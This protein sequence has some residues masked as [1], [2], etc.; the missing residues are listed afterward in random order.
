MGRPVRND[1]PQAGGISGSRIALA[2]AALIAVAAVGVSIARNTSADD[3]APAAASADT[4]APP[5]IAQAITQ[6]EARLKSNPDNVEDWQMLGWSFFETGKFAEA[7]TAY[8]RATR[9]APDSAV[10]WSS[11]G[12]ALVMAGDGSMPKDAEAAFAKAVALDPADPRA[13]YFLSVGK[14]LAGDHKGAIDGWLAL[15][16]DTPAGAPWE[17]DL[18]RT[19]EQVGTK[20]NIEVASRMNAIRPAPTASPPSP[21]TAAIPGPT[22]EQMQAATGIPPGQQDAM[23]RSM[24]DGLDA[25]LKADPDN[26]EG[27]MRLMR[28]RMVL[29]EADKARA[30][31]ANARAAF[32]GNADANARL[33][34]A[35][36]DLGIPGG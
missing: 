21:A 20:H 5:D 13:R 25:K 31:L 30:A 7:A 16:R 3:A 1:T 6:L 14:D 28:S 24:V 11:L 33:T 18:R 23:V 15:L 27:W 2:L 17:A 4:A 9:L 34:S 19:I 10:I 22:S 36:R 26:L 29:G 35:A 8:R 12:E 32:K